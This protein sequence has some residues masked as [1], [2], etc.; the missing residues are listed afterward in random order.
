MFCSSYVPFCA[1]QPIPFCFSRNGELAAGRESVRR[2][3][4]RVL[5]PLAAPR[6][7]ESGRRPF[8]WDARYRAPRATDPGGDAE[9]RFSSLSRKREEAAPIWSCSRWGLPCRPRCRG[10]GAL[11][12]HP[13]TLARRMRQR[14]VGGRFAFCG[15]FPGVAPA[16]RYPAPYFRGARTF[17]CRVKA[18]QRPSGRL[19]RA[20]LWRQRRRASS[21]M[22]GAGRVCVSDANKNIA[23]RIGGGA[24]DLE[25][26][27]YL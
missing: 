3:V 19:T 18:R 16:G 2:P 23:D 10:R 20:A 1:N 22:S 27:F 15:T 8:I 9:A 12:P 25:E 24:Q 14:R 13:F 6:G 4:S 21:A 26:P 7:A 17:L 11:L 5:S